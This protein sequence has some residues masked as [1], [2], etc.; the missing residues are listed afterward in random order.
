MDT[1]EKPIYALHGK[2]VSGLDFV[3]AFEAKTDKQ[4]LKYGTQLAKI[5]VDKRCKNE[6]WISKA[7]FDT[8]Q[9]LEKTNG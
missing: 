5:L 1:F 9:K 3:L 8:W 6:W 7:Q 2:G 4:A